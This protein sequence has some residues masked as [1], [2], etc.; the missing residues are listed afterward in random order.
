MLASAAYFKVG[1]F[2]WAF[3]R[4]LEPMNTTILSLCFTAII[5]HIMQLLKTTYTYPRYQVVH[6][7]YCPVRITA[8]KTYGTIA[9]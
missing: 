6:A 1:L 7:V 2:V 9:S 5:M 8:A 4:K 3:L